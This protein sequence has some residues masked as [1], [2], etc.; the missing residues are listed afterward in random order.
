MRTGCHGIGFAPAGIAERGFVFAF[1]RED[2]GISAA[3]GGSGYDPSPD[4]AHIAA[5]A[6]EECEFLLTW[7]PPV[8]RERSYSTGSGEDSC[9]LWLHLNDHLYAGRAY[10]IRNHGKTKC[11]KMFAPCGTLTRRSTAS[12]WIYADLKRREA[13]SDLRWS[14]SRPHD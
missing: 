6:V 12:T 8:Y 11:S 3:A 10:L 9:E 13:S 14:D 2:T 5:A 7:N 1:E 4:A